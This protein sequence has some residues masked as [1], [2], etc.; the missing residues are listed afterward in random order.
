MKYDEL[1]RRTGVNLGFDVLTSSHTSVIRDDMG[2]I[3]KQVLRMNETLRRSKTFNVQGN[4]GSILMPADTFLPHDV[5]FVETENGIRNKEELTNEEF[6]NLTEPNNTFTI[7]YTFVPQEGD[8]L[9]MK[10]S[11]KY[12]GKITVFYSYVPIEELDRYS[13]NPKIR[14]AFSDLLV[15]GTTILG[16]IRKQANMPKDATEVQYIGL[17]DSIKKYEDRYNKAFS[18]YG[19]LSKPRADSAIVLPDGLLSDPNMMVD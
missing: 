5:S 10:Y 9:R 6:E 12:I 17:R 14:T 7:F 3:L 15:Y 4:D 16:L 2:T 11:P 18:D 13:T 8:A 1:I 19:V